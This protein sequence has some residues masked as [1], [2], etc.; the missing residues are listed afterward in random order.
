MPC[1]SSLVLFGQ[2]KT[3]IRP[4]ISFYTT[5]VHVMEKKKNAHII[6]YFIFT[7]LFHMLNSELRDLGEILA[8]IT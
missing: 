3:V 5:G 6:I 2:R 1:F 4:K 7:I 8:D